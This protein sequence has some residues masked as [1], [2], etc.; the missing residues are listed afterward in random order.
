MVLRVFDSVS[1]QTQE[2]DLAPFGDC[3][4]VSFI[5]GD[6]LVVLVGR[7]HR[8]LYDGTVYQDNQYT[9]VVVNAVSGQI[10]PVGTDLFYDRA[11]GVKRKNLLVE[12]DY[13]VYCMGSLESSWELGYLAIQDLAIQD[14]R[15]LFWVGRCMT[16]TPGSWVRLAGRQ[17]CSAA[18]RRSPAG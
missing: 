14:H 5:D 12:R 8:F 6:D 11:Y 16:R 17:A 1:R 13:G 10:T 18:S 4:E 3:I 2:L 15:G 7:D 9:E